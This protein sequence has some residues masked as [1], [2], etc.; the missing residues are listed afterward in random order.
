MRLNN[1]LY[2]KSLIEAIILRQRNNPEV[3]LELRDILYAAR[4]ARA[5]K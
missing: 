5:K 2:T 3:G 1:G 4:Y